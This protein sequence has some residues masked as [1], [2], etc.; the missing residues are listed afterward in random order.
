MP[1]PSKEILKTG[2]FAKYQK[3]VDTIRLRIGVFA[4]S[5]SSRSRSELFKINICYRSD[6]LIA[7]NSIDLCMVIIGITVALE[8]FLNCQLCVS[9]EIGD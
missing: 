1:C 5:N 9:S 6:L 7:K 8:F 4:I 2:F 3:L